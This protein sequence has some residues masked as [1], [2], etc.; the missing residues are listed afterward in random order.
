MISN[1]YTQKQPTIYND[2]FYSH[3]FISITIKEEV[4][5]YVCAHSLCAP[6]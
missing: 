6:S 5:V 1:T 4:C 2:D 3:I